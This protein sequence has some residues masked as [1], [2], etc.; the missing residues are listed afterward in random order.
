MPTARWFGGRVGS[1]PGRPTCPGT[2]LAATGACSVWVVGQWRTE[3]ARMLATTEQSVTVFGHCSATWSQLHELAAHGLSEEAATAF[4]GGYV[5]V[6]ATADRTVV[7]TDPGNVWPIYTARCESGIVWGSSALALARMLGKAPDPEWLAVSVLAPD[8]PD[9]LAGRSAFADIAR[10]Q[11]GARITITARSIVE[12]V[13]RRPRCG[14]RDLRDG[15]PELRAALADAVGVRVHASTRPTAD[16]SG[17]L[18]SS[19]LTLL[20]AEAL[21]RG[22]R[23]ARKPTESVGAVTI[24]PVGRTSGGDMD[25]AALV[26]AANHRI[27]HL[28]CGLDLEHLPYSRMTDLTPP[29][30]EPALSTV[31]IARAVAELDLLRR[32]GSDCHLTGDGGDTL[33]GC[34]PG[35]L[36][37]LARAGR[38]MLLLRETVRWGRR[39]SAPVW[40]FLADAYRAG[41]GRRSAAVEPRFGAPRRGRWATP[42]ALA[43]LAEVVS[44]ARASPTSTRTPQSAD[45]M[46]TAMQFVGRTARS[47]AQVGEYYGVPVHNPFVDAQ[48]VRAV[49][50]VAAP[51][52]CSPSSYKPLLVAAMADLL[53]PAVARRRTKGDFLAEHYLGLRR[54]LAA[55][56]ELAHGRLAD[57]G[58]LDPVRM[59]TLLDLAAA[60][61]PVD[62]SD[63]EPVLAAE[64]WL[65]AVEAGPGSAEAARGQREG[66]VL[67]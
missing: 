2:P 57:E 52:R 28:L 55:V 43:T 33:L 34:H 19:S 63:I 47:D 23:D 14:E 36:A 46:I 42:K 25:Y 51:I 58:L 11:P 40:P 16:C 12:D 4:A 22:A 59:C 44:A 27:R 21:A 45:R 56:K 35:Y 6:E 60:G 7:L 66:V 62:F 41:S 26:A 37:D 48:V 67:R 30:D 20:A 65:R 5:L 64:V 1:G 3:E 9:L 61:M 54:N 10:A 13:L 38:H 18:D 17:G 15:A 39:L 53:P 8:L 31:T 49:A 32:T 50:P 24:H 29:S